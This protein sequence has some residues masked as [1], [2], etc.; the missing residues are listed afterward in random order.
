MKL[1]KAERETLRGK[2]GGRCAYCG[3]EL[4]NRWHADH[5][6]AV[7]RK[8]AFV[9]NNYRLRVRATGEVHRPERDTVENLNPACAPC[10]IDKH[11][12]SLE[13]WRQKLQ[14]AV[15][16]LERN[17][18]TYRHAVR[19]GLVRPTGASVVFY[20]ERIPSTPPAGQR[21]EGSE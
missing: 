11:S 14:G 12:M 6:E 4:G 3:C 16:V 20:F 19:F 13:A 9:R 17:H 1:T 5:I 18:P 10:N 15:G 2:Y 21:K 7:E 8:L